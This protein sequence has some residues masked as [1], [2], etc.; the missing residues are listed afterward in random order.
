MADSGILQVAID[1]RWTAIE[2]SDCI[3]EIAFLYDVRL[4]LESVDKWMSLSPN[5]RIELVLPPDAAIPPRDSYPIL[6]RVEDYHRFSSFYFPQH[7]LQIARIQ[8]GSPGVKDFLGLAAI[9]K[10][11]RLF[12]QFFFDGKERKRKALAND[13][14]RIDNARKFLQL[15][16][17]HAEAEQKIAAIERLTE[18]VDDKTR[19]VRKL[20][21]SG[22]IR[23][24][25]MLGEDVA[26]PARTLE[27]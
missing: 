25:Y 20:I 11:V 9:L 4:F 3:Q 27:G 16:V 5:G 2:M 26:R 13:A 19:A 15:R 22:K 18:L 24:V 7:V 12:F 1:E 8:Y 10:E 6:F 21:D 17:E 23:G 14:M